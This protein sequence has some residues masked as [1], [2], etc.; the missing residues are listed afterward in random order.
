MATDLNQTDDHNNPAIKRLA[1]GKLL[2]AYQPHGGQCYSETSTSADD[3]TAWAS[4]VSGSSNVAYA[5]LA[6]ATYN[7]RVYRFQRTGSSG[8]VFDYS[9]DDGATW[10]AHGTGLLTNT[11]QRPY[12][13]Y[14][15]TSGTRIDCLCTT[16]Q[17]NEA[18]G[19]SVYHYYIDI[20]ASTGARNYYK[21]DGTL[22]GADA[23]LPLEI[24]DLTLVYDGT[25]NEAWVW[26]CRYVNG[27]ITGIISVF[28]GGSDVHEYHRVR[29]NGSSWDTEKICDAGTTATPDYLYASE[30]YYSGGA[31]LDPLDEDVVYVSREFS[32][33]DFRIHRFEKSG[34]WAASTFLSQGQGGINA[35]PVAIDADGT[36]RVFWWSGRYNSYT[37]F[38]TVVMAHPAPQASSPKISPALLNSLIQ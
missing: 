8:Q 25:T 16:G 10:T 32:A 11:G 36:T 15:G 21:S 17:P 24:T 22:I 13:R 1:S 5:Q 28:V 2:S 14:W 23:T 27:Q 6:Q 29:W 7:N 34:S 18:T 19:C 35:R 33:T 26:D 31:C 9:D 12:N 37:N 4:A 38:Q 3:A 30:L 20:N